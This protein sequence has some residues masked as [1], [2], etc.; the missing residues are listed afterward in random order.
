MVGGVAARVTGSG[1][2]GIYIQ[3]GEECEHEV[4]L[5]YKTFRPIPGE[6]R[7]IVVLPKGAITFQRAPAAGV[8]VSRHIL[9]LETFHIQISISKVII[10]LREAP[11]TTENLRFRY[12]TKALF[13]LYP[14]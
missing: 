6:S 4:G 1:S 10:F 7:F 2:H 5:G 9:L 11:C 13:L 3:E 12:Q 14:I 8:Q